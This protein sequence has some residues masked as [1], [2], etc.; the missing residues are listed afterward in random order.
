MLQPASSLLLLLNYLKFA[1]FLVI[2]FW[3]DI[4]ISI[5]LIHGAG[6]GGCLRPGE[7]Q[8]QVFCCFWQRGVSV[9]RCLL[10]DQKILFLSEVIKFWNLKNT[11][12]YS[13]CANFKHDFPKMNI[14][15]ISKSIFSYISKQ[16]YWKFQDMLLGLFR[17]DWPG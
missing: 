9:T 11:G 5:K 3:A 14:F 6:G 7:D 4:V 16:S 2:S 15:A 12:N 17:R 10:L 1:I 8:N 13:T